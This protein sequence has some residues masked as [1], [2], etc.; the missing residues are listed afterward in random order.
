LKK[1][2]E[3]LQGG[4]VNFYSTYLSVQGKQV[5]MYRFPKREAT[6]MAMSYSPADVFD[7]GLTGRKI[8]GSVLMKKQ[9][10]Y[11]QNQHQNA[12]LWYYYCMFRA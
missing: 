11:V 1:V 8:T 7:L 10:D 5:A 4:E 2:R 6:L 9:A 3:V 12:V